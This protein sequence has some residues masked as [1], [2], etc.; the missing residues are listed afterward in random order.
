MRGADR[1]ASN[2]LAIGGL[3][4]CKLQANLQRAS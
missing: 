2:D 3:K 4:P 1:D